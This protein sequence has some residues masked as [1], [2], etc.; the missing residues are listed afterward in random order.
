MLWLQRLLRLCPVPTMFP[1]RSVPPML[2]LCAMPSVLPMRPVP[3]MRSVSS[4]RRLLRL[5][6]LF[7]M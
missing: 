5:Q 4:L 3:A 1:V 7:G 6:E 2:P